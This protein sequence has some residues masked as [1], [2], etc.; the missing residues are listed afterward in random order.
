MRINIDISALKSVIQN[1][2]NDNLDHKSLVSLIV[3]S[4][5]IIIGYL[6]TYRSPILR[7]L[8]K[9]GLTDVD[10]SFDCAAEIFA[11]SEDR[12]LKQLINFINSLRTDLKNIPEVELFLAYSSFVKKVANSNLAKMYYQ[13][14]PVGFKINRNIRDSVR[15]TGLFKLMK[16]NE[17]F[18][19]VINDVDPLLECEGFPLQTLEKK[20]YSGIRQFNNIPSYLNFLYNTLSNQDIYRRQLLLYDIVNI[21][22]SVQKVNEVILDEELTLEISTQSSDIDEIEIKDIR[23]KLEAI[24]KEQIYL[25][26]LGRS[27]LTIQES[28]AFYNAFQDIFTDYCTLGSNTSSLYKYLSKYLGINEKT[29]SDLYRTKMEYLLKLMKSEILTL[30]SDDI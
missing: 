3:M 13:Y 1:V 7:Y 16:Y 21:Y 30:L 22:K 18:T 12:E 23:E 2:L 25:K 26:Y 17:G 4:R 15:K 10:I 20:I 5:L 8:S 19:L 6:K 28:K 27:K 29:Y 24:I 11:V 14:D 9:Y